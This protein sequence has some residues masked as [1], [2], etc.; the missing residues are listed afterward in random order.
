ME[1]HP[2][3]FVAVGSLE[4]EFEINFL[5]IDNKFRK[6]PNNYLL[7]PGVGPII[8]TWGMKAVVAW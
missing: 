2:H 4:S 6:N 7:T 1:L 5:K 8:Y 3:R